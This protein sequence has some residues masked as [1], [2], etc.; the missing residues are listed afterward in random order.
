METLSAGLLLQSRNKELVD[1]AAPARP[2]ARPTPSR[3]SKPIARVDATTYRPPR[4]GAGPLVALL[5]QADPHSHH[6]RADNYS[7]SPDQ[8]LAHPRAQPKD[9]YQQRDGSQKSR[10][11][12]KE[13]YEHQQNANYALQSNQRYHEQTHQAENTYYR[14][15]QSQNY[16][17]KELLDRQNQ[18]LL[19]QQ[20]LYEQQRRAYEQE[21]QN[22]HYRE[23]QRRQQ[24]PYRYRLLPYAFDAGA[25][26]TIQRSVDLDPVAGS[27][28]Q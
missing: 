21:L 5:E 9:Q 19:Y 1:D 16:Y 17:Q 12:H 18:E 15:Q 11:E 14:P 27:R 6:R 23:L 8:L 22:Q 3:K 26:V 7:P 24:E 2:G 25:A 20:Q 10:N 13:Q 4:L 28:P